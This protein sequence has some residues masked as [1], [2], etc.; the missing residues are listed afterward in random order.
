MTLALCVLTAVTSFAQSAVLRGTITDPSGAVVVGA[1]VIVHNVNA[2][3][4]FATT[5]VNGVYTFS[6]LNAG[7]YS[8]EVVVP[9]FKVAK[10]A[11]VAVSDSHAATA[12]VHLQIDTVSTLVN[13]IDTTDPKGNYNVQTASMGPLG[14]V[15]TLNTP[16]TINTIPTNLMENQQSRTFSDALKYMPFAQMEA[17]G[18]MDVGRPQ[19]RGFEGTVIQNSRQDGLNIIDTTSYPMEMYDHIDVTSGVVGLYG[20]VQP[21]GVFNFILKRPTPKQTFKVDVDNDSPTLTTVNVDLGG[22][23]SKFIGYRVDVLHSNG[24]AYA[25]ESHRR[26]ELFSGALDFNLTPKTVVQLNGSTYS[27]H[28]LGYPGSFSYGSKVSPILLPARNA[29][30]A[31][32][33]QSWAGQDLYT[34]TVSANLHRGFGQWWHLTAGGIHQSAERSLFNVTNTFTDKLGNFKITA[35]PGWNQFFSDSNLAHFNGRFNTGKL[36]H[37]VVIGT[38]GYV[39]R[40]NTVGKFT[41]S[42]GASSYTLSASASNLYNPITVLRLNTA[43]PVYTYKSFTDSAQ[44]IIY[45]DTVSFGRRWMASFIGSSSWYH[46]RNFGVTG[47]DFGTVVTNTATSPNDKQ[48]GFSPSASLMYKPTT[49][50]SLYFTFARSMYPGDTVTVLSS[51]SGTALASQPMPFYTSTQYEIGYKVQFHGAEATVAAYRMDRPY[52][53]PISSY[54]NTDGNTVTNYA[55]I[56]D[57]VN[58]GLDV[59]IKG[60]LPANL[61]V[62]GGFTWLD[63]QLQGTGYPASN[64]KQVVGVPRI[65]SNILLEEQVS[66]VRGL[67]LNVNWHH[68][69]QRAGNTANTI[70]VDGYDTV[71]LGARYE[72]SVKYGD[73]TWRITASNVSDRAYWVSIFPGSI[74]GPA[75]TGYS[76]FL[77]TPRII[78]TS[79]R[80]AWSKGK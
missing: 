1:K 64:G 8:I 50:S 11:S 32:F 23:V 22:P 12:D 5:D 6:N 31:G 38:N 72:H 60:K 47:S 36:T 28:F 7:A 21:S 40:N 75:T 45:A 68:T 55:L 80:Y 39:W 62:F 37:D 25:S 54:V 74:N 71:D 30:I 59:M 52:A 14:V 27:D 66:K 79:V 46:N 15:E 76:A 24:T 3:N 77:G 65:Q 33:G 19:T 4:A 48:N 69:A 58:D 44:S 51:S 13:V 2:T 41:Y 16:W 34:H 17:R 42:D 63:P 49:D 10:V 53:A 61:N 20:P 56:G 57:Q 35:A 67:A 29:K 43:T 78:S 9:G 73:L 70:W 18:G 26:R